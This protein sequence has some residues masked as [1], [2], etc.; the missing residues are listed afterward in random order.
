MRHHVNLR[1]HSEDFIPFKDHLFWY[2]P[3]QD[4]GADDEEADGDGEPQADGD[5]DDDEGEDLAGLSSD[6]DEDMQIEDVILAQ[7]TKVCIHTIQ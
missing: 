1:F 6:E 4:G 5:E 3:E 7:F 2:P